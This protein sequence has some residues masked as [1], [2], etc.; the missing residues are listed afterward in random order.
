MVYGDIFM[1]E[2]TVEAEDKFEIAKLSEV[3][4]K[5]VFIKLLG[6]LCFLAQTRVEF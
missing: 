5:T 2:E 6:F 3:T 1:R 4:A